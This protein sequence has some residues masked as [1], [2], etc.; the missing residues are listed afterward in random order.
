[1]P[2]PQ[3]TIELREL[4][5]AWKIQTDALKRQYSLENIL[6]QYCKVTKL[7]PYHL[8]RVTAVMTA[9]SD[10]SK[11]L[12][13]WVDGQLLPAEPLLRDSAIHKK[14]EDNFIKD[15]INHAN[16]SLLFSGANFGLDSANIRY[17]LEKNDML[18][19]RECSKDGKHE[20]TC[21]FIANK[22]AESDSSP[23]RDSVILIFRW[24]TGTKPTGQACSSVRSP[25]ILMGLY[26]TEP[27][28]MDGRLVPRH[29]NLLAH[30]FGHFMGLVHPFPSLALELEELAELGGRNPRRLP[31]AE[32]NLGQMSQVTQQ[33]LEAQKAKAIECIATWAYTLE[34]DTGAVGIDGIEYVPKEYGIGDTPVDLGWGL[35]L[36][37]GHTAL[38]GVHQYNFKRYAHDDLAKE[39]GDD[40]WTPKP[41]ALPTLT[42]S[43]TLTDKVRRN[44][45]SYWAGYFDHAEHRFSANQVRL[46]HYVLDN[47]RS[48][49]I[50]R[51]VNRRVCTYHW[52]LP[53]KMKE[54][55]WPRWWPDFL[56]KY[57]P[58]PVDVFERHIR[59]LQQAGR[60]MDASEPGED[61][62][63]HSTLSVPARDQS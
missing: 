31:L 38:E 12:G 15:W 49:L 47:W 54:I 19:R 20:E 39:E 55:I 28:W 9:K 33:E 6:Q 27:R 58:W 60:L 30:E 26:E 59:S 29:N 37:H 14:P 46:M 36:L 24:G 21:N 5:R 4:S 25:Y 56:P 8:L 63:V 18:H 61:C 32:A 52:L 11:P 3:P 40:W 34:Q 13:E 51:T 16:L 2:V 53:P 23:Y 17:V 42:D 48:G 7:K 35:S 62:G 45:M 10:G 57:E 41:G 22:A 43:V 1:M 44:I 50:G